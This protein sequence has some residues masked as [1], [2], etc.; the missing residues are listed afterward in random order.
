MSQLSVDKILADD[1]AGQLGT[2]R[3]Y[4]RSQWAKTRFGRDEIVIFKE[5]FRVADYGENRFGKVQYG[6]NGNLRG[7][8]L[9]GGIYQHRRKGRKKSVWLLPYYQPKNPRTEEQ[10]AG[11]GKFARGVAAWQALGEQE[12]EKRRKASRRK[13][14]SAYNVFLTRFMKTEGA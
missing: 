14:C 2:A 8:F 12:R 13:N 6:E 5:R 4:G 9:A 10:Q 3:F 7:G 1:G 11:R